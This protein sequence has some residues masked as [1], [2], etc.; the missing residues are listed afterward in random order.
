MDVVTFERMTT[1]FGFLAILLA[2]WAGVRF[3]AGKSAAPAAAPGAA[4]R[5]AGVRALGDG[6]RAILMQVAGQDVLVVT[7]R[8]A[9][10]AVV[11][12]GRP[13]TTDQPA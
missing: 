8:R 9:A 13:A 12:L 1:L 10:A 11:P 6:S 7:Q 5:I 4:L 2:V 3:V